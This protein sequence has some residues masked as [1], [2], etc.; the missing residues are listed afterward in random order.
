MSQGDFIGLAKLENELG[1]VDD[2]LKVLPSSATTPGNID[3]KGGNPGKKV[4]DK[5]DSGIVTDDLESNKNKTFV[6][7]EDEELEEEI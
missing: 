3:D 7:E 5:Q 2:M 4:E 6:I 1:L